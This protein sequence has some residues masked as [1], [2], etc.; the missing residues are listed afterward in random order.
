MKDYLEHKLGGGRV[1]SQKQFLENDRKVLKFF[2]KYEG[3][4]YY[5]H[6]FLSDDSVEIR[7]VKIPNSGRQDFPVFLKR[8]KLPKVFEIAQPGEVGESNFYKDKDIEVL[9]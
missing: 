6:Y 7:E 9:L 4:K 8:R 5:V 3:L 2:A 1:L